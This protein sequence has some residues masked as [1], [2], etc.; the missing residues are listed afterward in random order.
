MNNIKR[1]SEII[2]KKRELTRS[3]KPRYATRKLTIGLVSCM[4]GFTLIFSPMSSIASE[5]EGISNESKQEDDQSHESNKDT[6][7]QDEKGLSLT[8]EQKK[9]LKE[10]G[11]TDEEIQT[12]L[13]EADSNKAKDENFDFDRFI[14]AKIKDKTKKKEKESGV[15]DDQELEASEEKIPNSVNSPGKDREANPNDKKKVDAETSATYYTKAN[16]ENK[17]KDK[18]RWKVEDDQNLVRVSGS[19]PVQMNDIDYDGTFVDA[20]GRTVLRLVYK[21]KTQA[22][23]GVWYRALIN[24]GDLDKY[25]DYDLSY[26]LGKDGKTQYKF[27]D[28]KNVVGKG[29]DLG[30][31]TGDRT[32]NRANLPIN[33]VL[34]DGVDLNTLKNENYIVQM[35]VANGDYTK[36]YAYAPKGTSMDYST[37]TKTTA[38]DLGDKLGNLFIKGGL[39]NDSNNATNQEFFMSEF[40]SNPDKYP[41]KSNLGIIRTQYMGQTNPIVR[42]TVGGQPFAYTQAFDANLVKYMK[43]D[44]KGNVAYV[45]VM[46]NGRVLSPVTKNVGIPKDK[47]NYSKDR[48]LAYIVIGTKDFTK[49]GVKVVNVDKLDQHVML[50]GFYITAIDYVVDKGQFE[51]T[52]SNDKVRKLNYAMMSGWTN[53]NK[54]GWVSYEKSYDDKYVVDQGESYLIDTGDDPTGGQIMV[55]VG[56]DQAILRKPQGYYNGYV[57]GKGANDAITEY[58]NGVYKI[59]LREGATINKDDKLKIYMP[60]TSKHDKPVNFL[61]IH[62][63]SKHNQ[64][65]AELTLQ[66]DRN[67]DMHLFKADKKE[68]FKLK[69]T[70]KGGK[71]GEIIF[72][73]K[74]FWQYKDN[75]HV[76]KGIPNTA[77]D[78][79]GGNFC[80][81]TTKL[82]PGADIFVESIG[83]DGNKIDNQTS[84]FKYRSLEKS[85]DNVKLLT[86][87]DHSDKK[88]VLS[89]NKSLY[90][91]YQQIFTNDYAEGNVYE[92][93]KAV[94][95]NE[96]DFNKDTTEIVGYTKYDGGKV[97]TLYEN[98]MGSLIAKVEAGSNEYD[99]K[100]NLTKDVRKDLTLAKENIFDPQF[101]GVEKLYKA[102]EYRVN[103]AKMLAYQSD[104]KTDKTLT[105]LKDMKFVANAS[106]GSSLPSD[107]FETR[108]RARILFDATEGKLSDGTKQAVK[109]APDNV[110]FYG[111]DGYTA[112]GFEGANVEAN[113]GDKFPDA[114]KADGNKKFLGWVTAEGKKALQGKTTVSA[115][116]FNKVDK[117]DIFRADTPVTKHLVVY[118]IYSDETT[119]TFDA[120]GGKFGDDKEQTTV[121]VDNG[122]VTAPT[123]TRDGYDFKGWADSKD[124]K[125]ANPN[126]LTGV[127]APKTAYAVWEKK[128]EEALQLN[129]P[130]KVEV[131]DISSLT[132]DEI[133]EVKKAVAD[134]NKDK[135]IT[136]ADVTVA[137]DGTVTVKKGDQ[138]GTIEKDNTV[139]QKLVENTFNP[140]KEPVKVDKIGELKPD[141]IAA[142]KKAVKDANPERNFKDNE[143]TVEADGTVKINQGGK[144]G[145]IPADKTVVQKDTILDLKKPTEKVEVKDPTILTQKEKEEV[146]EKVKDANKDKL[147][148]DADVKVDSKGNVTVKDGEKTGTLEAK[149]TVKQFTRDGKTLNPPAEKV[150]VSNKNQ[151]NETEKQAVRDQVKKANPDL[152]F[153]DEEIEVDANGTVTVPMGEGKVGTF[154]PEQTIEEAKDTDKIIKLVA[155][156]KTEVVDASKLTKD[157]KDKVIKA[158]KDANQNLPEDVKIEVADD[159]AVTVTQGS[160]ESQK[161]G[162]LSQKDTVEE[163]LKAPTVTAN[164][165]GSVIAKPKD[166]KAE[167]IKVTYTPKGSETPTTLTATKGNDGKWKL[168]EGTDKAITIDENTGEITIPADK[169]KNDTDVKAIAK[170]GE[171]TSEGATVKSKDEQAPESPKVTV[172]DD[173]NIEITPPADEDTK[174]VTVTYKDKDGNDQTL[175]AT[176]DGN[177]WKLPEGT[178]TSIKIDQTSG[179]ITLPKDKVKGGTEIS[180]KA[181]DEAGNESTEAGKAKLPA[182]SDKF[183]PAY[184]EA[185]GKVNTQATIT[186]PNF[187][188]EAGADVSKPEGIT[189]ELGKNHPQGAKIDADGKITYTPQASD[190]GKEIKIPVVVK[191]S[192][193]STDTLEASLKVHDTTAPQAPTVTANKDGSVTVTPPTDKDTKEVSVTYKDNDGNEKTVTATK[194]PQTG[195]WSV[196]EGSDVTVDP[197]KGV[198][199]VPADKVKDGTEVS[200]KAKDKTGNEST[201]AGKATAKTP[202]DKKAPAAP[203]VEA[204]D[205]GDVTVTPPTDADTKEVEVTYTPEGQTS[206]VKVTATKGDNGKWTVPEGSDITVDPDTGVITVPADKVKDGT[207]V[208]AV[209]KDKTGNASTPTD[210]SKA[211]AKTPA[212]KKAPAAPKVEAKDN[213]DVTV[214]PP[215]DADTK[216][217]EVT[218]VPTGKTEAVKVTATKDPQTGKWSVP[219]G[220][221]VKVDPDSGVITVP[222]D[223]VKDGTEVS[224]KAKDKTGNESTEAGKATAKTPADKKAPAAPK[225]EA[226]DNG[227][228]TVTPPTDADTKEVEV[229]YTPEGQTSPVKVTATKGDNGKWT[230]PEGSDITVDP[231]TGVITVPADKVADGTEVSAK[232]K[233][234]TGNESTEAGKA[235]AKTPADKKA[236]AAPKVEAKD[237]GDVTVTP[238]TDADTKEVEVTY[239]PTGKTEAVKVTATK[240][241]QTGKWSVPEGS[242]VK[243]DPDSG[244]ITVPADK[245]ADGTEVSAKAK[246]KTGNES[247]EAGKATAKTPA[248]KKAPAA[249]KVEAKDNGDVT[250]TPPTD[251]DTK[252]VE[253]T[254]TPE[255]QTSPVKVT[256]T[257]G[258]D[259]TWTFSPADSGLKVEDG[260]IVI[261]ADKVKDGTEVSAV[262]KDKTGNAST[263]TDT[264]KANAKTPADKK[265]PAAPKVEAK[266]NGDVTVTPPTD[267]D[268]KEVEVTYTPEGATE[269]KTVTATKG[270]D[271]TWTFNPADSGL[272]V[273]DGKIVIPADKVKDGTEVSAVAKDKT[274][275][276]STPTDTSKA[277]AKTPADKKAPAAPKVEAKD[278]G[279]VTVTPPTDAD[280]KEVEVTYTPEGA[281]EPKTVT[282]TKGDDG[283][284]TFNPADSGLKVEDGKIVIPADKVKDGTEVSAVA[285]DKAGNPSIPTDTSKA[286]AKTPVDTTAPTVKAPESQVIVANSKALT[287]EEKGKV[288]KAVE[289]ANKDGSGN[290]TLPEGATIEVSDDGSATI[291]DKTGKEIGK[292]SP[293]K[294]VKQDDSKLAVKAPENPVEVTNPDEVTAEEQ[295][296]IKEAIKKANPDLKLEDKD[297]T[298]DDKG[299]VTIKKDGKEAKLSSAQTVKKAQTSAKTILAP[300]K[301]VEVIDPANLTAEEKAAVEKAV[302]DANKDLP[303]DA[304]VSVGNDG[305]VIISDK[306]SSELG[307]LNP[308][309]TVKKKS[310]GQGTTSG[311]GGQESGEAILI[312]VPDEL[313]LVKDSKRLTAK[314]KEAVREAIR[315]ANPSLA[316][317][318][319]IEVSDDGSLII[320]DRN[321]KLLGKISGSK[322]VR[323]D[324][325]TLDIQIPASIRVKDR[326]NLSDE[327]KEAIKKAIIKANPGLN[328]L[329]DDISIGADGSVIVKKNGKEARIDADR[330][331]M[332]DE[333]SSQ[334]NS[335]TATTIADRIDPIL[336]Q[337]KIEVN[338]KDHLSEEEKGQ[339]EKAIKESNKDKFPE[340]TEIKVNNDGEAK[341]IYPDGSRDSIDGSKLVE[342]KSRGKENRKT[343]SSNVKTGIESESGT[344]LSLLASVSALVALKKKKRK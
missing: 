168:P 256:A 12:I 330:L 182:L 89:I 96:G 300:A 174:S 304:I 218:Y 185:D 39:Q 91:P 197:D 248:D 65:A 136:E 83:A 130:E 115:E 196:P 322:T 18:S 343:N 195:K 298:V 203:K 110:K 309:Q 141:E 212:D 208:S 132:S 202:A 27:E 260:K 306:A 109:I 99:D 79:L 152:D 210:T 82:E 224:A 243:V 206:P 113:T 294:T 215:T 143:I 44:S 85:K 51:N 188:N 227:D 329:L 308:A 166:D 35:R 47:I 234:K 76:L 161:V 186:G 25:I 144:V 244:V 278:N 119:V 179:V 97:R 225:V 237:N 262:A 293:D 154:Q 13:E 223:K 254:Y 42:E 288:K 72:T 328:L 246:D 21:E 292:I 285:K 264:S 103:L 289:D 46:T 15:K 274:G 275:N 191:Y 242:D 118:A 235:T 263:P 324:A 311:E 145:K 204:K 232:A 296:K 23:S 270:D 128:P 335:Q 87:T 86:W 5:A 245:V 32:N 135:G 138:T 112:N 299:N 137:K 310:Q 84:W 139:T 313:V 16:W 125:E 190:E 48:K 53:P 95:K 249:P 165:D 214:T 284:W 333:N 205:N 268:T 194:D 63:G 8:D 81:D 104:D 147:T 281:T 295:G 162:Q 239:V 233:D 251:A 189:F 55:Q 2:E 22:T 58:A 4:L 70:L 342:E 142:I 146:A 252:E 3:K 107:L 80:L 36:I 325:S 178:D 279:D 117:K 88:S 291:K 320:K 344:L 9:A 64:G 323:E 129:N 258:D 148:N 49:D 230:V 41:D 164:K 226:K 19:D 193:G 11:F 326:R 33:L 78:G 169:I 341:I 163:K 247:T 240:D 54:D 62:N 229:T 45:N 158:I 219:E 336:P 155:P 176:K 198:I 187:K 67:I 181:K 14:Q 60:Y 120:N 105:L 317:D 221:D 238:P 6:Q 140:P 315:K 156:A 231:D 151:L 167:E 257:K 126:I 287:D 282:A 319:S 286:N 228:V 250:V 269:P 37:Y 273:E 20:N 207:E 122:S 236:P 157:E 303:T 160:G 183:T 101:N 297:I 272:K 17:I 116:E 283:T 71:Q 334:D 312:K 1:F 321:G 29:F 123:P 253:V 211:N 318:A 74:V 90:T 106:D 24:F 266:D 102:Y 133:A 30:L 73:P 302:R 170:D 108:V 327:D 217:V 331:N 127:T 220:S 192:D 57:T 184:T 307:R 305:S 28:V 280:T 199:T 68:T 98:R 339:V 175:L 241:P 93:P 38:V 337:K 200:A 172:K 301:P 150:K 114:P 153:K 124:A 26:V 261:P 111:E 40:I 10:A 267:A 201:E 100:G 61:E 7:I 338:D 34:K 52:F 180:S 259:G 265:A 92:N 173:G 59:T 159:G 271:G 216:E 177:K 149:D 332:V 75:D 277:N 171:K 131:K 213:G 50:S 134:A 77:T 31:A 69:Y 316:K 276:A 314:E 340:G 222:A 290:S 66:K 56:G 255:G 209:A 94:P 43:A 121:K